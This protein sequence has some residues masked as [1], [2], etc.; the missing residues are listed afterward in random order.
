MVVVA[1]GTAAV[2]TS[3]VTQLIQG[4]IAAVVTALVIAVIVVVIRLTA[5]GGSAIIRRASKGKLDPSNII[6]P[7]ADDVAHAASQDA[8]R[9]INGHS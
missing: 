8:R 9:Y 4:I 3:A 2:A 6:E 1:A 7:I 5:R